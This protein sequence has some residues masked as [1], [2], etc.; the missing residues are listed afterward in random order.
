M[1]LSKLQNEYDLLQRIAIDDEAAFSELFLA[2]HQELGIFVNSLL[3]NKES[4]KE[5]VHDIFIK[6][7][8]NRSDLH[9]IADFTAYLFI[10]ARNHTLNKIRCMVNEEKKLGSYLQAVGFQKEISEE[11][12]GYLEAHYELVEKAVHELPPQQQKVFTLRQQGLKNPEIA[13]RLNISSASVAKYQQ[14]AL[15]FISEYVK[16]Y[17][18]IYTLLYLQA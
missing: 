3:N 11:E 14:L 2:Y 6:V 17:G 12:T 13:E 7:W 9:K 18:I 16:T 15:R 1:L 8:I 4:T 10:V 5:A